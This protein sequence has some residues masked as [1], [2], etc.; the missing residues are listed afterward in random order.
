[1]L[2]SALSSRPN[3][4]SPPRF[5][6]L[7]QVSYFADFDLSRREQRP[8]FCNF[9]SLFYLPFIK[10]I[11][12]VS[13]KSLNPFVWPS[14]PPLASTLT[15]LYLRQSNVEEETLVQLLLV[16][17]NL[18]IFEYD[19][20]CET[21]DRQFHCTHLNCTKLGHALQE[22]KTS[23][24]TPII[25]VNFL[26][27]STSDAGGSFFSYRCIFGNLGSLA[28]F[29][30]LKT[31]TISLVVLLGYIP[32]PGARLVGNL[33]SGLHYFCCTNQMVCWDAQE[34]TDE[35]VLGRFRE[36]LG[37]ESSLEL[38]CLELSA[39][40]EYYLWYDNI[41]QEIMR[42]CED[43]GILYEFSGHSPY[44]ESWLA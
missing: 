36:Y 32:H 41:Q 42:L 34:W 2:Q 30:K 38:E 33:P 18:K 12:G 9:Q 6:E 39:V 24:E 37:A 1:M 13:W 31:L 19:F 35:A 43:V 10:T 3:L 29:S 11:R 15:N 25:S 8:K 17:P 20:L 21:H 14:D 5:Q 40:G 27:G 22:M 26:V 23:L 7:K 4:A 16:T 28:D 44:R